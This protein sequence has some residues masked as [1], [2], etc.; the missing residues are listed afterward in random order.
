MSENIWGEFYSELIL[1]SLISL[2]KTYKEIKLLLFTFIITIKNPTRLLSA[3]NYNIKFLSASKSSKL[4]L[5]LVFLFITLH[6]FF[7][8]TVSNNNIDQLMQEYFIFFAYIISIIII[9]IYS[10]LFNIS[11]NFKINNTNQTGNL[12]VYM[13]NVIY[14]VI[15]ITNLL[16]ISPND[17]V[18]ILTGFASIFSIYYIV[19]IGKFLK[20]KV[21]SILINCLIIIILVTFLVWLNLIFT[22]SYDIEILNEETTTH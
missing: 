19:K 16:Y 10:Y 8:F 18:W 12:L 21:I 17:S 1:D 22:T 2:K 4:I 15:I 3:E 7:D 20:Y 11:G 6:V 13:F 5:K 14:F 9:L